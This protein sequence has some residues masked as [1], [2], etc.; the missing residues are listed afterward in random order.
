MCCITFGGFNI[1][2]TAF[3]K[4]RYSLHLLLLKN[5]MVNYPRHNDTQR[6]RSQKGILLYT[7]QLIYYPESSLPAFFKIFGPFPASFFFIF[8]V[9]IQLTVNKCSINLANDWIR[10]ADLWYRKRPLCQ[11]SHN[12]CPIIFAI[13]GNYILTMAYLVLVH[14]SFNSL[15]TSY[16]IVTRLL[17]NENHEILIYNFAKCKV[18]LSP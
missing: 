5:S 9:S 18:Y 14:L 10:T 17:H 16:V 6:C 12:H 3:F 13:L 4:G 1:N 15:F 2:T 7:I 11:L 8:A